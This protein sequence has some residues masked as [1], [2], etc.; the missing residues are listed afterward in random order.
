MSESDVNVF[1]PYKEHWDT[2]KSTRIGKTLKLICYC[3]FWQW[4][5]PKEITGIQ[6]HVNRSCRLVKNGN[7]FKVVCNCPRK[8]PVDKI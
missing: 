1:D 8:Y 6:S 2:C 3:G 7:Y 5:N 4:I